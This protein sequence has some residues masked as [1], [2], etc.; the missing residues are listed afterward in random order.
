MALFVSRVF[1]VKMIMWCVS[2]LLVVY[3]IV[4]GLFIVLCY[5]Y[6]Y[7]DVTCETLKCSGSERFK[8][9]ELHLCAS[10]Q[11]PLGSFYF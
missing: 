11:H 6:K 4:Q 7:R 3:E 2:S 1:K 9:L 10:L 8:S 5:Y